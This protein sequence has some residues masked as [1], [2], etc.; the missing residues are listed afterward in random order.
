MKR[1]SLIALVFVWVAMFGALQVSRQVFDRLPHLEDEFA[2]LYQARVFENGDIT[3]DTLYPNRAYWQPFTINHEGQRFSKYPPGWSMLLALGTGTNAPWVVNAWFAGLT[4]A[5]VYR[6]GRELYDPTAGVIAAILLSLSPIALLQ[7][8]SLMSHTSALFFATAFAYG[9][10]RLERIG[11]GRGRV[12]WGAL[13]GLALGMLVANR[14][15]ASL[16]VALPFIAYS[17]LRLAWLLLRDRRT[18]F[19]AF[20]GL[21]VLGLC[22]I[23]LGMLFPAYNRAVIGDPTKNLYTLIW[24]YDRWG[25]GEG[26]GRYGGSTQ[27]EFTASGIKIS[28][29]THAG[30]SFERG[31]DQTERDTT[32]YFRDLYG[33]VEPPARFTNRFIPTNDCLVPDDQPGYSWL[34]VPFAGLFVLGAAWTARPQEGGRLRRGFGLLWAFLTRAKWSLLLGALAASVIFIHIPYWIGAGVYSARY[35]YE[36]T[37]AFVL[38]SGA[39]FSALAHLAD[40]LRLRGGLYALLVAALA[41]TV[42]SYTPQRFE[43]LTG[44]GNITDELYQDVQARRA[45]PDVPVMV[46]ATGDHH[47]RDMAALMAITDPRAEADIIGLRDSDQRDF[48]S[49]RAQ[50]PDREIFFILDETLYHIHELDP[51]Q[52]DAFATPPE[53]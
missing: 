7:A 38:L 14:P 34:L 17:L 5:L 21:V 42:I 39:G 41:F 28:M 18:L 16:G 51:A 48:R 49:L 24:E 25:F 53:S 11:A 20:R 32:C 10:W 4:V 19:P 31:W 13:A 26:I 36:A 52:Y 46:I 8:G 2:Y 27:D 22:A 29:T 50:H 23:L 9:L 12:F 30:H 35:Y 40:G 6:F 43:M 33:W 44:Y 45:S 47:W 1:S 37:A 3:A 15:L